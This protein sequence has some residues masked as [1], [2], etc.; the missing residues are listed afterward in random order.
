MKWVVLEENPNPDNYIVVV[1]AEKSKKLRIESFTH[2]VF[3]DENKA[4]ERAR[5]VRDQFGVSMIRIFYSE[6]RSMSE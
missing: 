1:F 5:Q 2:S 6:S 3:T 4:L